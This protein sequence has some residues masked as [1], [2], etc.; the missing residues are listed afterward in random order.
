VCE[1]S[2][3]TCGSFSSPLLP[4][5]LLCVAGPGALLRPTD[6]THVNVK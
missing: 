2:E 4:L 5:P 1:S 3:L 6:Q